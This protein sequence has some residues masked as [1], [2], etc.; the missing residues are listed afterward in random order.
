[1]WD[2]WWTT[3]NWGRSTSVFPA[4]HSIDSSTLIIVRG[5]C[6]KPI[7][8]LVIVVSVLFRSKI[9]EKGGNVNLLSAIYVIKRVA[10]PT[11]H[12]PAAPAPLKPGTFLPAAEERSHFSQ[13]LN[14]GRSL[15]RVKF[16]FIQQMA[17]IQ[18]HKYIQT[19]GFFLQHIYIY[20]YIPLVSW[21]LPNWR[22]VR[23]KKLLNC[24]WNSEIGHCEKCS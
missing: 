17:L 13:P 23:K 20:I 8:S 11:L 19:D 1:M 21:S 5:W 22:R 9:E 24:K 6:N 12:I 18:I 15:K 14:E 3:Q 7:V 16:S 2:L 4:K 10:G